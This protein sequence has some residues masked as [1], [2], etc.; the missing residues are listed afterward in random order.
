MC[1][2]PLWYFLSKET[3]PPKDL[4]TILR[5]V[6]RLSLDK[7]RELLRILQLLLAVP[8]EKELRD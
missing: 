2:F 8:G 3:P 5:L 1:G 7:Q 6:D 4:E